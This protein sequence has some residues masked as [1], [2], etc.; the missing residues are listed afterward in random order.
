MTEKPKVVFKVY[1]SLKSLT[2][3]HTQI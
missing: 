3:Q 2:K 1:L